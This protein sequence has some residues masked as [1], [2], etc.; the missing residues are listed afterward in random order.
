MKRTAD[1]LA[2]GHLPRLMDRL[3]RF[4]LAELPF[5]LLEE[6]ATYFA[7]PEAAAVVT[8]SKS[9]HAAFTRTV[10]KYI[11]LS[12]YG[13]NLPRF[14]SAWERYCHLVR[15]VRITSDFINRFPPFP[16]PNLVRLTVNF[17]DKT[18]AMLSRY[19]LPY[20]QRLSLIVSGNRYKLEFFVGLVAWINKAHRRK[21]KLAVRWWFTVDSVYRVGFRYV[22]YVLTHIAMLEYHEFHI[23]LGTKCYREMTEMSKLATIVKHLE[24]RLSDLRC[25]FANPEQLLVVGQ[26]FIFPRIESL[27]VSFDEDVDEDDGSDDE[28]RYRTDFS[29]LSGS[30]PMVTRFVL[31]LLSFDC[32]T[33]VQKVFTQQWPTVVDLVIYNPSDDSDGD[34]GAW[35]HAV[36]ACP[37]LERLTFVRW[38]MLLGLDELVQLSPHLRR[39]SVLDC[40]ALI[41]LHLL[42][43]SGP[44]QRRQIEDLLKQRPHQLL[45]SL[46]HVDLCHFELDAGML[47]LV[48]CLAPNLKSIVAG[49]EDM[50]EIEELT[51]KLFAGQKST[52]VQRLVFGMNGASKFNVKD[53][54][55]FIGMFPNLESLAA[56][57]ECLVKL[58]NLHENNPKLVIREY[59]QSKADEELYKWFYPQ[60]EIGGDTT[61][62]Y[63]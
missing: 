20:L 7:R 27:T 33:F 30:I 16:P 62:H 19:E 4:P 31:E 10:W 3:E 26:E 60:F 47:H 36:Q 48:I 5:D 18:C 38:E 39:F 41:L 24:I 45:N 12:S 17:N 11:D 43:L 59:N 21:Q 53:A 50:F 35:K 58:D 23:S 44:L 6:I 46:V 25:R 14:E 51:L 40:D 37:N 13:F 55:A 57:K 56:P 52:S 9:F 28:Y 49:I 32:H 34:T 29:I 8:V 61:I 42:R 1:Q 15:S 63:T 22:D 2:S 54:I